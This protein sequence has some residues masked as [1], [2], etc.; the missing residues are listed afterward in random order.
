[1]KS[2]IEWKQWGKSDPLFAVTTWPGKSKADPIPWND[3]EFYEVGASDW[4]DCLPYWDEY[5]IDRESCIEVGCGAGRITR[6]LQTIFSKVY[7][8]D[9]SKDMIQY[10]QRFTNRTKVTFLLTDGLKIPLDADQVTAAFS[11][12]V[13]QHFDNVEC[14]AAYF[15]ELHRVMMRGATLM[16]HLPILLTPRSR[17]FSLAEKCSRMKQNI[18]G[19]PKRFLIGLGYPAKYMRMTVYPAKWIYKSLP[20]IGFKDVHVRVVPTRSSD[21]L[22]P[23]ILARKA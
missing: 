17:F 2:N 8:I 21:D 23:F 19:V 5:G 16:V 7:A 1:M 9:V 6:Q 12:H 4:S 10:A 15:R 18:V 13:F 20:A 3:E 22:V 14:G 11:T